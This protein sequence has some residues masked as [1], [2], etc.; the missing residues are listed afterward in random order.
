M[1]DTEK[2]LRKALVGLVGTDDPRELRRRALT[3]EPI[4]VRPDR[5]VSLYAINMLLRTQ[6]KSPA[7]TGKET[8]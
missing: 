5:R 6:P 4:A 1:S 7:K 3:D 8:T 2:A